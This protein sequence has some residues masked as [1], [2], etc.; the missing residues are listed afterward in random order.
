[1]KKESKVKTLKVNVIEHEPENITAKVKVTKQEPERIQLNITK[2]SRG[3][4]EE[5]RLRVERA[6]LTIF[7]GYNE[8]DQPK[9]DEKSFGRGVVVP[10]EYILT[11]G[12]CVAYNLEGSMVLG[13]YYWEKIKTEDQ[14]LLASPV[15]V[16]PLIDIAA[17]GEPDGQ[18]ENGIDFMCWYEEME[19]VPVCFDRYDR[20][21]EFV[22]YIFN[23][24][25]EWIKGMA[26]VFD[27]NGKFLWIKFEKPIKGGTSGSPV[28]NERGELVGI[29]SSGTDDGRVPRPC[30]ALPVWLCDEI[31]ETQKNI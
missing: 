3:L 29:I 8:I 23:H 26:E 18:D 24:K 4:T 28:V 9:N 20:N 1:M 19:P 7:T 27:P 17:L 14:E 2:K 21:S 10:G 12:H 30:R 6:T 22:V 13:D 25:K 11:A 15:A 5:H 16:E 31:N